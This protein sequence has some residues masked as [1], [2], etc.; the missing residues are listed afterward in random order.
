MANDVKLTFVGDS[1]SLERAARSS[2]DAVESVGTSATSA[3]QE[4]NRAAG[5]AQTFGQKMGDLGA[6]TTGMT[7]AIEGAAGAMQGLADIQDFSRQKAQRLAQAQND[8]R[9]AQEDM[10]QSTRD[11]AQAGIDAKQ[12]QIDQQQAL[13]DQKT[14]Q[15]DY[16]KAVKEHGKDSAEAKQAL[17]DM[18]QAGLDVEQA[19]EDA[20]QATRDASQANIDGKQS[21]IDLNDAMHEAN[22]PKLQQY[23]DVLNLVT[24][25]LTGLVGI[26]GL[27]T[28]AQWLWNIAQMASPTTW[29]IIAIIALVA[30]IV[31]IAT[32]TDWFQKLWKKAW[33]GIQLYIKV[34]KAVWSGV[35][36]GIVAAF[37]FL[38][39]AVAAYA[40]FWVSSWSKVINFVRGVPGKIKGFFSGL[41]GWFKS[42]GS[43]IINGIINGIKNGFGRLADVARNA[44]K[45]ALNAAKKFLGISSPSKVFRDEVGKQMAAGMALGVEGNMSVVHQAV[46]AVPMPSLGEQARGAMPTVSSG[47][48]VDPDRRDRP[49]KIVV[50]GSGDVE[51][52]LGALLQKIARNGHLKALAI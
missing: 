51:R 36:Q 44:A 16:N 30:I 29:I 2:A 8:V 18:K 49:V 46:Q 12:A 20:A 4:F 33:E 21:Q 40:S 43:N 34:F 39:N 19:Q 23:A 14:A 17:I 5:D 41:G 10:A 11:A 1:K 47:E 37:N 26:I 22:P 31:V 13:L 48:T 42:V 50:E 32:K 38:K 9:Q 24:P 3:S 7:D 6:A 15:E 35:W 45:S 27:V 52:A 25:I 28:A